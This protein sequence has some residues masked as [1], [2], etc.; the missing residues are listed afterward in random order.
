[1]DEI[2]EIRKKHYSLAHQCLDMALNIDVGFD[3]E[4]FVTKLEASKHGMQI[5]NNFE[6]MKRISDST[7][8]RMI[9]LFVEE[10]SSR[11]EEIKKI[12]PS[13]KD[14]KVEF[15]NDENQ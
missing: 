10:P 15:K 11:L 6:L 5:V 7:Q 3:R 14:L 13:L 9:N 2:S 1:M 12:I 8:I 4:E